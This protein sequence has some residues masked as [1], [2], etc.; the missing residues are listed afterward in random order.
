[1]ELRIISPQENGFIQEIQWNN[2]ELK[3]AIAA[4]MEDYKGLVFTEETIKE[5]RKDRADLNKL[6]TAI[7]NERKRVKKL[8]MDPYN[9]FEQQVK[10]VLGLIDEPIRLIDAQIKEVDLAKKEEKR[11]EIQKLFE[12]IGFQ[13]FVTLDMIWDEKWL[14][15]TVSLAKIEEQMK[16]IMYQIGDAV[17]TIHKLP[18]F[19]FEAMEIYKKTLNLSQAIAEGQRLADIQK[20]KE[21][22]RI[23]RE[24]AEEERRKAEEKKAAQEETEQVFLPVTK[25]EN[26]EV[27]VKEESKEVESV[28]QLDF[29]VWGTRE[30]LLAL[31]NYMNE[32][33][34]RFG[35]V[36]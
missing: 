23:A 9:K 34:L 11:V 36:E 8:C 17:L 18:E 3:T 25:E 33:H 2:E 22:A 35:K 24:K 32:N 28:L 5:G 21:E 26:L 14:N 31:R 13:S 16:S 19:S 20:R 4:K 12:T 1:M 10:E 6:R 30:Q 15:V 27:S 29:R 7:D